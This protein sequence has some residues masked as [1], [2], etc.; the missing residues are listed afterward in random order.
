MAG[1]SVGAQPAKLL[2]SI[3]RAE[4]LAALSA[5]ATLVSGNRRLARAMR[6]TYHAARLAEG[7]RAWSS[8]VILPWEAWTAGLWAEAASRS[9]EDPLLRLGSDQE[10]LLWERIIDEADGKTLL[11]VEET[12][13]AAREAWALIHEWRLD[14]AALETSLAPD[15]IQFRRWAEMFESECAR[16]GW[17]DAAR[18]VASLPALLECVEVPGVLLL[19]GLDELTP[20]QEALLALLRVRG[21]TVQVVE[22]APGRNVECVRACF[23]SPREEIRA[24]AR[25]ARELVDA[26]EPGPIG[27]V[28]PDLASRRAEVERIFREAL[29]PPSLFAGGSAS[30]GLFQ[31]SAG[32]PFARYPPVRAALLA[33]GL[34]PDSVELATFSA[35]LRSEYVAGGEPERPA[36]ALLDRRL[37]E[38]GLPQVHLRDLF[39]P[40]ERSLQLFGAVQMWKGLWQRLPPSAPPGRWADLFAELLEALGWPGE[41]SLNSQERQILAEWSELLADFAALGATSRPLRLGQAVL[42]IER[43]AAERMFQ[44]EGEAGPVEVLGLLEA[45]G[46]EHNRLWVARLDDETWPGEA[47]PNPFLPYELQR[48]LR[49]PHSSPER[50]LAFAQTRLSNLVAGAGRVVASW[51]KADGDRELGP[52]PLILEFPESEWAAPPA[53]SLWESQR[54]DAVHE[55]FT[56]ESGPPLGTEER[57][58]GGSQIFAYQAHC[59]FRAFARWRLGAEKLPTAVPGLDARDRG[60]LAHLLFERLW[61]ELG[62]SAGLQRP[63]EALREAV[64]CAADVALASLAEK[65]GER[66]PPRFGQVERRRLS[67]LGMSWLRIERDRASPFRIVEAERRRAVSVG[68]LEVN[69]QIDRIDELEDGRHVLIDYKTGSSTPSEWDK[70]RPLEPQVPLYA[71][72]HNAR[73]AA[74]LFA[75]LKPGEPGFKGK[76]EPDAGVPHGRRSAADGLLTAVQVDEWRSNLEALAA[77]FLQ[78]RAVVEPRDGNCGYCDATPLCRVTELGLLA[79]GEDEEGTEK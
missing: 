2:P 52:S 68:G 27:V 17:I 5:G 45:A 7:L 19:A 53:R 21:T 12:A 24:A 54:A 38:Q 18:S 35:W 77:E 63:D 58:P 28:V 3:S 20:A 8:P 73:V 15:V 79:D 41:R 26:G 6:E 62:G 30:E 55:A 59:P 31:I 69:V 72:T 10:L 14:R 29:D 66:L 44:P 71:V 67:E 13:R 47:R 61:D 11:A 16:E 60:I 9:T 49:L 65:R 48:E 40:S 36:R 64:E 51:A 70:A 37:R 23:T 22:P 1:M 78:G 57:A 42:L 74:A 34:R 32:T 39:L 56:D 25:W 75:N 50:E 46:A 43:M 4:A 76:A 33:L